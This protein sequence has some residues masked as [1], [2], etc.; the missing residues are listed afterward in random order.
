[1]LTLGTLKGLALAAGCDGIADGE[2]KFMA[3]IADS[4][5]ALRDMEYRCDDLP[6]HLMPSFASLSSSL[7]SLSSSSSSSA[8]AS[9]SGESGYTQNVVEAQ[10]GNAAAGRRSEQ[11]SDRFWCGLGYDEIFVHVDDN[12]FSGRGG[13]LT[14]AAALP[15]R[16]L[17]TK[18][19]EAEAEADYLETLLLRAEERERRKEEAAEK[20]TRLRDS[21]GGGGG[22]EIEEEEEK[23]SDFERAAG[24][25]SWHD[26]NQN[27]EAKPEPQATRRIGDGDFWDD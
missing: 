10:D 12:G 2:I 17:S 26:V 3:T 8:S 16:V 5:A 1:M 19:E 27:H 20:A 14:A 4:N 13:A 15:I 18:D 11:G 25:L 9:A 6:S 23:S 22:E 24:A 21:S 7:S